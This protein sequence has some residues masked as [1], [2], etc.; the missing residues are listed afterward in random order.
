MHQLFQLTNSATRITELTSSC[1]DLIM[2]QSPH[3]VSRT[4][5]LPAICSDHSVPCAYIRNTV[6]KNKPFKRI[7]YN[8]SK[9]DSNKFCNLL[10]NVNWRNIIENDT[11]YL[12]A[13]NFTDTFFEIAKQCMP[14]KTILVRQ[15]DALWINDEIRILTE[16]RRKKIHKKA[17]QSNRE[18][19][20][21]ININ[22]E[23][24]WSKA[25]CLDH[26]C[27]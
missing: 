7:I 27:F 11:I 6:I 12:S 10:T 15:R 4:E 22:Q 9:L 18:A 13:A 8:Y 1:L 26:L 25:L 16:K 20:N 21:V 14:A 2:T 23:Q 17:K 19:D 5:V 3:I 24:R